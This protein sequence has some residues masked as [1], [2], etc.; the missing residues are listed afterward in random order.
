M[1]VFVLIQ[2]H[3]NEHGYVD[4][5]ISGVFLDEQVARAR[6]SAE[7]QRAY[8]QGLV[9]EDDDSPDGEW[10]VAWKVEEYRVS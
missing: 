9:M 10:Q 6:E 8:Q 4:T 1:T 3:Q 2:E 5:S 7:R